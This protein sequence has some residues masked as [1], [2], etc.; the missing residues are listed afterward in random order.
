MN[1]EQQQEA[2]LEERQT[3]RDIIEVKF[4]SLRRFC[5]ISER[6]YHSFRN[7]LNREPIS[8]WQI[9]EIR[10]AHNDCMS[11]ANRILDTEISGSELAF[12]RTRFE[13]VGESFSSLARKTELARTSIRD[14]MDGKVRKKNAVYEKLLNFFTNGKS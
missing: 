10:R 12:L 7:M 3:L 6:D 13:Q 14:M 1:K 5:E 11:M 9:D 2:W 4:E 8:K